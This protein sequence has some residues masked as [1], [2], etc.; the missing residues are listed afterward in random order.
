MAEDTDKKFAKKARKLGEAG[1][2]QRNAML[3]FVKTGAGVPRESASA[4]S[5]KDILC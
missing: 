4:I 3:P 1:A 5:S 2:A